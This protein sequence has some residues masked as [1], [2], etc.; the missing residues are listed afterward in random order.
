MGTQASHGAVVPFVP[1]RLAGRRTVTP[2]T[3]KNRKREIYKTE[4]CE[5]ARQSLANAAAFSTATPTRK[6][7]EFYFY[8]WPT[9][10]TSESDA[11]I[12]PALSASP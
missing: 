9:T 12:D 1:L 6:R 4:R 5:R 8:D 7:N 11:Y 3:P 10:R 2:V